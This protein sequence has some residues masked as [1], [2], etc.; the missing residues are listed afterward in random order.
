M[1]C[2]SGVLIEGDLQRS[3]PWKKGYSEDAIALLSSV[4]V[5]LN[6][7]CTSCNFTKCHS[8]LYEIDNGNPCGWI[9][10]FQGL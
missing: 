4:V 3:K 6:H 7:E 2:W 8:D 9:L 10:V 1:F 5:I